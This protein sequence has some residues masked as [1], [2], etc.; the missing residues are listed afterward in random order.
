M[1]GLMATINEKDSIIEGLMKEHGVDY[2]TAYS[3]WENNVL[4][5]YG[6]YCDELI[7]AQTGYQE[8]SMGLLE[9]FLMEQSIAEAGGTTNA[10]VKLR[11]QNDEKI[12]EI[13]SGYELAL[14]S[15]A[16]GETQING[17]YFDSAQEAMDYADLVRDYRV[18]QQ[19]ITGE[20]EVKA[21]AMVALQE[22]EITQERY[23]Q[24]VDSSDKKIAVLQSE[25]DAMGTIMQSAEGNVSGAWNDIWKAIDQAESE[26]IPKSIT[27][28]EEFIKTLEE[29]FS[30]GANMSEALVTAYDK[31]TGASQKTSESVQ[32]DFQNMDSGTKAS[33][34]NV[35]TY[36]DDL[37]YSMED[38]VKEVNSMQGST[39]ISTDQV[40]AYF[41]W[42]ARDGGQSLDLASKDMENTGDSAYTMRD[43]IQKATSGT[44]T[45][46]RNLKGNL[47]SDLIDIQDEFGYTGEDAGTMSS[48][49]DSASRDSAA[50]GRYLENEM[51]R[52]LNLT[53][54]N[55]F[56]TERDI[57]SSTSGMKSDIGSV[58]GKE[59]EVKAKF[60]ET[61]Y[62]SLW[63]KIGS[64]ISSPKTF[65]FKS[66]FTSQGKD[67]GVQPISFGDVYTE[68]IYGMKDA[69]VKT[70][71]LSTFA[72]D[73]V[74]AYATK[75]TAASN[76]VSNS[77][78][79]YNSYSYSSILSR[80]NSNN[81]L[82]NM[83]KNMID[84]MNENSGININL[85]IEHFENNSKEDINQ[86]MK[87]IS[88]YL[89][90]HKKR[91]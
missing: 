38:A 19:Q 67:A 39:K 7:K 9:N 32:I 43:D 78:S 88:Y 11:E 16:Q 82:L 75:D 12:K 6:I 81:Q 41:R 64:L 45:N 74:S 15:I 61:G 3:E 72:D 52:Y 26:G 85:N 27:R 37:G 60:T 56:S 34:N 20:E 57:S 29:C 40:A 86:L 66:L 59:V 8:E 30:N 31:V 21:L 90:V 46:I 36:M 44:S 33:L 28:N 18:A 49:V 77:V 69:G 5:Q 65:S 76:L 51:R 4:E 84:N 62:S 47:S 73:G 48:D 17:I 50:A 42:L 25:A 79:N 14:A 68:D 23:N 70:I 1:D 87:E 13:N 71:S 35:V 89:E 53:S 63:G 55:F 83:M 80:N 22:G 2:E 58:K 10:I 91:W 54:G 24:I